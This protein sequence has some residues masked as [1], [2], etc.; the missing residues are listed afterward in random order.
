MNQCNRCAMSLFSYA[1][2]SKAI[3]CN[4]NLS[5]AIFSYADLTNANLSRVQALGTDF[6]AAL[7]TGICLENWNI[8]SDT[9]LDNIDCQYYYM[10]SDNRKRVPSSGQLAS[11]TFTKLQQSRIAVE[12]QQLLQ[13]LEQ[14]NPT[15]TEAD[16]KAFINIYISPEKKRKLINALKEGGR[17]LIEEFLDNPYVNVVIR[18]I[19]GWNNA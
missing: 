9:K 6:T 16:K 3:L 11:G 15:A 14:Q 7:F 1:D 4:A 19:E 18:I 8:N 17:A 10:E 12:I 5:E 13:L 2:L